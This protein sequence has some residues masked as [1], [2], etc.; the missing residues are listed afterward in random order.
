VARAQRIIEGQNVEI[1][2]T[3]WRYASVVEGQ[4]R[5]V[6]AFRQA[7]IRGD[8]DPKMWQLVPARRQALVDE[9][10]EDS[11]CRAERAVM[12]FQIDRA[13][14]DYLALAADLREGIHLVGLGAQDPLTRFTTEITMAFRRME[15][16]IDGAVL[17]VLEH[18]RVDG[19]R[20]N[21]EGMG[22][23]GPSSTWTYLVNDDPFRH[24]IGMM[25]TGPG[26]STFAMYAVAM[27]RP[28]LLVWGLVD[29]LLEGARDVRRIRSAGEV[30][31]Q[32]HRPCSSGR[33]DRHSLRVYCPNGRGAG[34]P[35]VLP[36]RDDGDADGRRS[37]AEQARCRAAEPR[38]GRPVRR[39]DAAS[40]HSGS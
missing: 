6:M 21:V 15:R 8:E 13:W 22:I 4:R 37:G 26:R 31:E 3:L 17:D 14:R 34:P 20:V 12:L 11:V 18:V 1:R 19:G 16:A 10:G 36:R 40:G 33:P 39:P 23:R 7:I 32:A 5:Q 9:V 30:E 28:L 2:K 25:L 27:M 38:C 29:R 35:R 24:Q